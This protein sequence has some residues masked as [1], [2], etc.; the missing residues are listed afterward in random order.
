MELAPSLL[1]A[2]C[3]KR[4]CFGPSFPSAPFCCHSARQTQQIHRRFVSNPNWGQGFVNDEKTGS[5]YHCCVSIIAGGYHPWWE[6]LSPCPPVLRLFLI[7]NRLARQV[8]VLLL[9]LSSWSSGFR[10]WLGGRGEGA[11]ERGILASIAT[12]RQG[13]SKEK[14]TVVLGREGWTSTD[15]SAASLWARSRCR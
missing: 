11:S 13:E 9:I 6:A 8:N 15:A 3:R 12:G 7:L 14:A 5:R 2:A 10:C 1:L 4:L